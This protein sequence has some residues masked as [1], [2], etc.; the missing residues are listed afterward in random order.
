MEPELFAA[1]LDA[2][3]H[4][5]AVAL[6]FHAAESHRDETRGSEVGER[7]FEFFY[8]SM[9]GESPNATAKLGTQALAQYLYYLMGESSLPRQL[10]EPLTAGCREDWQARGLNPRRTEELDEL[11]ARWFR[12][13]IHG[14][15]DAVR[16]QHDEAEDL[17]VIADVREAP[18]TAHAGEA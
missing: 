4:P 2:R 3:A 18:E 17:E 11:Y 6:H 9:Y 1:W 10:T 16:E 5:C 15:L 8:R 13:L 7:A 14:E 12:L